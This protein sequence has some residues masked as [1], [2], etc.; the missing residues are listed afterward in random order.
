M[1]FHAAPATDERYVLGEGPFWDA[2]RGRLLW[3][4]ITA[5][6]VYSGSFGN[7]RVIP[8]LLLTLPG[9]VGAVVSSADG[10][11]L[12]AGPDRLYTVSPEGVVT[13]GIR[14]LGAGTASR[15]NDGG[16]DPAGRFLVG[17]LALD[18][19]AGD[20]VLVRVEDDG[21]VSVLDDDLGL[22]NGLAFAP[23][24]AVLYSVDTAAGLVWMRD[25]DSSSGDVGGRREFL[26]LDAKPDGLCVD[27]DGNLWIAM[28][29]SAEV[30]CYSAA[31]EQVGVVDVA[32]PNTTSVAFVGAGLDTLLITT[33]SE[34]LSDDQLARFPHS[35][36]LFIADVGIRGL[37]VP[38][39]AGSK[40][41]DRV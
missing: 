28:W 15:L 10:E 38:G 33:A 29:G 5:G 8:E 24:G 39:W 40:T 1:R 20:E 13:P 35:G 27:V 9:T 22:S 31:G 41:V 26:R 3:V 16:C 18:A 36:R 2:S 17:S 25:Y 34:Q 23:G 7:G 37:P 6:E 11:L 21:S 32:A 19:R 12:V 14:I 30:R 4:D